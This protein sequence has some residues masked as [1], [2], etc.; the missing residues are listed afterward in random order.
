MASKTHNKSMKNKKS[1]KIN[2]KRQYKGGSN[3]GPVSY[4]SSQSNP[5][6]TYDLN[7][8]EVDPSRDI[9]SA[10]NLVG[11]KK[12]SR[13]N[14]QNSSK[15]MK[16]GIIHPLRQELFYNNYGNNHPSLI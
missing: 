2:R 13:R 1:R 10:R 14:R 5:Y 15:K 16:G 12:K 3:F 9:Q 11:G 6:T 4:I 7:K 8:Y